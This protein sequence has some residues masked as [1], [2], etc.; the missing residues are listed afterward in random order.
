MGA[1]PR[2]QDVGAAAGEHID[3]LAGLGIDDKG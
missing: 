2:L 1:Q 3:P